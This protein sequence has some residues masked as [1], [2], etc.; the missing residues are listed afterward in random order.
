MGVFKINP[1]PLDI[2]LVFVFIPF[3]FYIYSIH[4]CIYNSREPF[5]LILND[6][7]EPYY[8]IRE[9]GPAAG[10]PVQFHAPFIKR[11]PLFGII[12]MPVAN[13]G[14]A[15]VSVVQ[16]LADNQPCNHHGVHLGG[17]CA[18]QVMR[19]EVFDPGGFKHRIVT[20]ADLK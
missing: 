6:I 12:A 19:G 13:G 10:E 16:Y 11:N 15:A 5:R 4:D 18:S 14:N 17:C 2:G 1:M 9:E 20:P 3:E 8:V 7:L